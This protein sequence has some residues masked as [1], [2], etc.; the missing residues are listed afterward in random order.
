MDPNTNELRENALDQTKLGGD[1]AKAVALA[2]LY[3]GDAVREC[4]PDGLEDAVRC[5]A[6]EVGSV[7]VTM[8]GG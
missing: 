8:Q 7:A 2:I 5:I 3:L 6:S 1:P 4:A